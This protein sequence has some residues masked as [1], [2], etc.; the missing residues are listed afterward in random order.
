MPYEYC[1]QRWAADF[2][3]SKSLSVILLYIIIISAFDIACIM[4]FVKSNKDVS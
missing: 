3:V 1:E 2:P 4:H